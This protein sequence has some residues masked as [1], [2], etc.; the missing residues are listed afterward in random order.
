MAFEK[1]L[2]FGEIGERVA[3]L[4]LLESPK[5]KQVMDVRHDQFFQDRDIDFLTLKPN[6]DVDRWEVKTDRQAHQ[7]GN[8]VFET[9]S[10]SNEGCLARS[11]A[12][13]IWYHL[14]A[15]GEDIIIDFAKLKGYVLHKQ[16]KEVP[17]GD[18]ASG[19]LLNIQELIDYQVAT[20]R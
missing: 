9:K 7:T 5:I 12:Q 18:N 13:W 2:Q 3:W 14:E 8:I 20:R 15:T 16:P 1:D 6:G 11:Q 17:M 4:E 19:Y 10:N